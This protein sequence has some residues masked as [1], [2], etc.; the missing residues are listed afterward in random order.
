MKITGIN[1]YHSISRRG[2]LLCLDINVCTL[3]NHP[4]P[5]ADRTC[6][7]TLA[8]F[9]SHYTATQMVSQHNK[10]EI[11]AGARKYGWTSR[12]QCERTCSTTASADPEDLITHAGVWNTNQDRHENR[13]NGCRVSRKTRF[14]VIW[15]I[16]KRLQRGVQNQTKLLVLGAD[17]GSHTHFYSHSRLCL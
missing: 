3:R 17:L 9:E 10:N 8:I 5:W 7:V 16:H 2:N 4:T 14:S 11:Q 1:R 15:L 13:A 12:C 6:L